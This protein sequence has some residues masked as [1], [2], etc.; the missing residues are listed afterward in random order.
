MNDDAHNQRKLNPWELGAAAFFFLIGLYM[1]ATGS[2]FGVG[3]I[4]RI[5]PGFFPVSIGVLMMGL[6][7]AIAFEVRHSLAGPPK[8]PLRVVLVI[9]VALFLFVTLVNT[10]G[11]IIATFSLI[12][13]SRFAEP[14]SN[15]V[16]SVVLAA[17]LALF[18]W[19][20]F[21][22]GFNLPLKAFWW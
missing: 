16:G 1:V 18:G 4:T 20:V 7:V 14:G 6:S 5:G 10:A 9:G 12:F 22:F 13:V 15:V 19:L 3:T 8:I 2:G 21:I 17:C 11:F